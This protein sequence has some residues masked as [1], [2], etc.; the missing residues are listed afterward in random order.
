MLY[1]LQCDSDQEGRVLLLVLHRP[2]FNTF[3]K[4][5]LPLWTLDAGHISPLNTRGQNNTSLVAHNQIVL[6]KVPTHWYRR[7]DV[8]LLVSHRGPPCQFVPQNP[9]ISTLHTTTAHLL[10]NTQ[11]P[12]IRVWSDLYFLEGFVLSSSVSEYL[13]SFL[14]NLSVR[15]TLKARV[16]LPFLIPGSPEDVFREWLR[17]FPLA[18]C[19]IGANSVSFGNTMVTTP[20]P[21][22]PPQ[23]RDHIRSERLFGHSNYLSPLRSWYPA[24]WISGFKTGVRSL[25]LASSRAVWWPTVARL[26][27]QSKGLVF[28]PWRLSVSESSPR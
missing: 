15:D 8:L 12:S 28:C 27:I 4:V 9:S 6:K 11:C 26:W 2:L 13:H 7:S 3:S 14:L 5:I 24:M 16:S 20:C 1:Y 21:S 23:P 10:S 25:A 22:K 17:T 19:A 18:S